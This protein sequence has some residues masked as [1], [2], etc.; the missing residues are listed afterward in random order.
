MK[1][2]FALAVVGVVC[3]ATAAQA[4]PIVNSATGLA[5]PATT[6][7][8]S[9]VAVAPGTALGNQF[10]A[11]G[12][13]GGTNLFIDGELGTGLP[14][15]NGDR[16]NNF[17]ALGGPFLNPTTITFTQPI[18]GAAFNMISNPGTS[19]FEALLGGNVVE[20]FTGTTDLSSTNNFFGFTGITFDS[21]RI[22]GGGVNGAFAI[23][24]LQIGAAAATPEPATLA[25]FGALAA[26][27]FGLRR[28]VKPT[29]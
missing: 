12:L 28:R 24:N 20:S 4:N 27:V 16:L 6:I 17:D 1:R 26:G 5:S 25:V 11:F 7:T 23:D 14:N 29:A 22:T 9:E 10:A 15:I 18:T 3:A 13:Q 2:L 19:A 21:I 8:F